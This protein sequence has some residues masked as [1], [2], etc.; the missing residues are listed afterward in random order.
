MWHSFT[1]WKIAASVACQLVHN[2]LLPC[3]ILTPRH[4]H[5]PRESA[6]ARAGRLSCA[7][8]SLCR[9]KYR[10]SFDSDLIRL[11]WT[12]SSE[13]QE[14]MCFVWETSLFGSLLIVLSAEVKELTESRQSRNDTH[15]CADCRLH[16]SRLHYSLSG[17]FTL[18]RFSRRWQWSC[19]RRVGF[20]SSHK[21]TLWAERQGHKHTSGC[22]LPALGWSGGLLA[23]AGLS[24]ARGRSDYSV[25]S[26]MTITVFLFSWLW[27]FAQH[28]IND[29]AFTETHRRPLPAESSDYR[30]F[31]LTNG[32]CDWDTA[33]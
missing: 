29:R 23:P 22:A 5:K 31:L 33:F 7:P 26:F 1:S 6:S 2:T 21:G 20:S 4:R 27:F 14:R 28:L 15:S 18:G 3:Q 24:A 16:N 10:S 12:C 32:Q 17:P 11:H 13:N 8:P 9:S 30:W 25:W 19:L